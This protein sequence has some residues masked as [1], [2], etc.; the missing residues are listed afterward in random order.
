MFQEKLFGDL[1]IWQDDTMR[2][3]AGQY[4]AHGLALFFFFHEYVVYFVFLKSASN[5][6][7]PIENQ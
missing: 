1:A 7:I 6:Y 3:L 2:A 5:H 4:D